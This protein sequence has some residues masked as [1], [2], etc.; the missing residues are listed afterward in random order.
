MH[1]LEFWNPSFVLRCVRETFVRSAVY[2]SWETRCSSL[3]P[4]LRTARSHLVFHI[5][6][7]GCCPKCFRPQ[8]DKYISNSSVPCWPVIGIFL[9][10]E[11]FTFHNLL[12]CSNFPDWAILCFIFSYW[13]ATLNVFTPPFYYWCLWLA[14]IG[15]GETPILSRV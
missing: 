2:F 6:L 10:I 12:L 9:H 1:K 5:I 11:C 13:A 3:T 7:L 4:V 14:K 8:F 15:K